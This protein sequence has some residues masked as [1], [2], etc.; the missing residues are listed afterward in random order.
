MAQV[1]VVS[2]PAGVGK[3]TLVARVL[4]R[5]PEVWL[6]TS[7]TTRAPRPGEIEGVHYRFISEEQFDELLAADG[8]LEWALVHGAARYGTPRA[9]VEQAVADG[10]TVI[11]EIELQGARQIKQTWP[12]AAF[13]FVA[14]PSWDELVNRLVG[15]NTETP[16]QRERR[17]E[18][19]R[20]ELAAQREFD[21]VIV[22]AELGQATDELVDLLGLKSAR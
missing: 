15:R 6:S 18:T 3:G 5:H 7:V 21:H 1:N 22:N 8:L 13:I 17:L 4:Q 2:G 11:L 14:P 20:G 10:R 19:A 12:E 9:A 16:A